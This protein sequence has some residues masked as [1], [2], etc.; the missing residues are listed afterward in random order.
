MIY[1]RIQLL[2]LFSLLLAQAFAQNQ[3]S[4]KDI[5]TFA[6]KAYDITYKKP[7]GFT[8]LKLSRYWWMPGD[9]SWG[10]GLPYDLMFQSKDSNCMI[11]YSPVLLFSQAPFNLFSASDQVRRELAAA[12]GMENKKGYLKNTLGIDYDKYMTIWVR[13]EARRSFN[14]DSVFIV[15]LPLKNAYRDKYNYCTGIYV[16]KKDRP[17][18]FFKCFFTEEGKQQEQKYLKPLYKKVRYRNEEWRYDE[19]N[20]GRLNHKIFFPGRYK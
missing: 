4:Y 6:S 14:A 11:L 10:I 13:E 17:D 19:Q 20:I 3:V 2:F 15:E 18:L 16:S 8:D 7:K 12:L 9:K 1:K 5:S